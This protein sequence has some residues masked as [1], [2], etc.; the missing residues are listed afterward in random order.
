MKKIALVIALFLV[1]IAQAQLLNTSGMPVF[2]VGAMEFSKGKIDTMIL[3]IEEQQK[4][5]SGG[6]QLPPGA[7]EQ[8]KYTVVKNIVGAELLKLEAVSQKLKP[9]Q[10][11]VDSLYESQMALYV[12]KL[13]SK[14]NVEKY[15]AQQ[16]IT[17]ND[18]KDKVKESV[19]SDQLLRK[20]VTEPGIPTE[21]EIKAYY[22]KHKK[23]LPINDT[24]SGFQILLKTGKG[25]TKESKETK[26][27]FLNGL[28]AQVKMGK[29][30]FDRLAA[31]H[32]DDDGAKRNG[33]HMGRFT[34]K[35]MK[36]QFAKA[37]RGLKVG[38]ITKA[39]E[40]PLGIHI[41]YLFEKN[42]GK[43]E[44]YKELIAQ[45]IYQE[46]MIKRQSKV[47]EYLKSLEKKFPVVYYDK[48]YDPAAL[49]IPGLR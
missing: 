26:K 37:V 24:I 25:E 22:T 47:E 2:K 19:V 49:S 43:L 4:M 16:G 27:E 11:T 18:I 12:N 44:S 20:V 45:A 29:A 9:K 48:S 38:K 10:T 5:S 41:F 36:P 46:E 40:T 35:D 21:K 14:E 3:V 32:S 6:Q 7:R 42:D 13:K 28:A 15:L 33:G 8:I 17:L 31:Q 23:E 30:Q 1:T 39:F 34:L